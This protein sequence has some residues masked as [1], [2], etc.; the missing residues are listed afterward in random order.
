[1]APSTFKTPAA[2]AA[3]SSM[4]GTWARRHPASSFGRSKTLQS[5]RHRR[6]PFTASQQDWIISRRHHATWR[7]SH[8]PPVPPTPNE[9]VS[10]RQKGAAVT[11]PLRQKGCSGECTSFSGR[12]C[13]GGDTIRNNGA[14]R[15]RFPP[16]RGAR[17][18][19]RAQSAEAGVRVCW[20]ATRIVGA[21]H[22]RPRVGFDYLVTPVSREASVRP[23]TC[24]LL[25]QLYYPSWLP[26]CLTLWLRGGVFGLAIQFS[27]EEHT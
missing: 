17:V 6:D 8:A 14:S 25:L 2:T 26:Q 1:M 19:S 9:R 13:C 12:S 20:W 5:G 16:P 22:Y 4:P 7:R 21:A 23:V 15:Q 10:Q 24:N 3:L 11:C 27:S 18:T